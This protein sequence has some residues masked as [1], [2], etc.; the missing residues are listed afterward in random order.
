VARV[1]GLDPSLTSFG[2]A[3]LGSAGQEPE[4]WRWQPGKLT[5]CARLQFFQRNVDAAVFGCD[6]VVMEGVV[7]S[8]VVNAEAHLNLAGLHWVIRM[9]LFEMEIPV[10]VVTPS[11]RQQYVTGSGRADKDAC[12][13]AAARRWPGVPFSGNDEAD[14][15]TLCHMG[16][17]WA[18]FPL[19][20][21]PAVQ[22]AV[23]SRIVPAKKSGNRVIPA[24][25][26][27]DWPAGLREKL[28]A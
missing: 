14:A 12:L 28:A 23:L 11:Q 10:V 21:M 9:R 7:G 24:H 18:G 4:L 19:T 22:R 15:F 5:G 26:A 6:F 20:A 17:D 1:L 8:R 2:G 27:I 16:A 13:L 3:R 25:P